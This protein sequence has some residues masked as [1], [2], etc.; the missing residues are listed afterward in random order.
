MAYTTQFPADME[1]PCIRAV[2]HSILKLDDLV[3]AIF[4]QHK[5]PGGKE[6]EGSASVPA[7][8][9]AAAKK[10]QFTKTALRLWIQEV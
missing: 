3:S 8:A 7:S 4:E 6:N 5:A 2:H 9:A 1:E 10:P